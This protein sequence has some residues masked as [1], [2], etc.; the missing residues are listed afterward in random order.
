MYKPVLQMIKKREEAIAEGL[1]QAE[2][3]KIALERTLIEEK[4]VLAKAQE[5]SKK[6]IEDSKL[7]AIEIS[8][9]IEENTKLAAEKTLLEARAQILQESQDAESRIAQ[10]ITVIAEALLAKSLE[11]VFGEREQKQ[12]LDKALKQIKKVN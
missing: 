10:R 5:E 9:E 2:E 6:I 8:K 7:Q 3:A 4:K 11:G 1:K 12:I